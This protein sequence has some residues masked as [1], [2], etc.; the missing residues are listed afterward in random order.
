M[1]RHLAF[2]LSGEEYAARW[3]LKQGYAVLERRFRCP[4]GEIDIIAKQGN[5]I[6]FVEVKARHH[7]GYGSPAEA[8]TWG[9][10]RKLL[11]TAQLWLLQKGLTEA[12]CRMD[13]IE[14]LQQEE[15]PLIHHI[16][17][18]FGM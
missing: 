1:A 14:V 16:P 3:L 12:A 11:R 7:A 17:N 13:V 10:Q 15:D 5:V 6:V 2:G 4:M 18:A 9:K 8:V